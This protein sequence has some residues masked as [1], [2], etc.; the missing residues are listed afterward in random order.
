MEVAKLSA[1]R[2]LG[3]ALVLT[4]LGLVLAGA[5]G[6]GMAGGPG[7]TGEGDIFSPPLQVEKM[8]F[9][10]DT[11]TPDITRLDFVRVTMDRETLAELDPG[12][13]DTT[14]GSYAGCGS[15]TTECFDLYVQLKDASDA[16]LG[17]PKV[18]HN[19]GN[20]IDGA[21]KSVDVS[22]FD[23]NVNIADIES[24]AFTICGRHE[25]GDGDFHCKTPP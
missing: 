15:A 5:A 18:V 4:A 22:F 14:A 10:P 21:P 25:S 23:D 3:V 12:D 8:K 20:G 24:I 11:E 13:F 19:F 7:A 17:T 6:L 1:M 2:W 16:G 9:F